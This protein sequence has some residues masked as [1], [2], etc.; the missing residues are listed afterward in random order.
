VVSHKRKLDTVVKPIRAATHPSGVAR[1]PAGQLRP[2]VMEAKIGKGHSTKAARC[3]PGSL[4]YAFANDSREPSEVARIPAGQLRSV[5]MDAKAQGA[6]TL[7]DAVHPSPARIPALRKKTAASCVP[8]RTPRTRRTPRTDAKYFPCL[9]T[10]T[11]DDGGSDSDDSL[12]EILSRMGSDIKNVAFTAEVEYVEAPLWDFLDN[13]DSWH[14]LWYTAP[15]LRE[16]G[17]RPLCDL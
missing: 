12:D 1:I 16:Q 11:S 13:D 17:I 2:V 7:A 9:A 8:L 15:E 6:T 5:V 4:W 14:A 3:I 10:D